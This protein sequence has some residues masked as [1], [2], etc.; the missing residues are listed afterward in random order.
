MD[1]RTDGKEESEMLFTQT[2]YTCCNICMVH[3]IL[4]R[5][6]Q[7]ISCNKQTPIPAET[8]IFDGIECVVIGC[9][10]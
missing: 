4:F 6:E 5:M 8:L 2:T 10:N 1:G 3:G 7:T 9:D